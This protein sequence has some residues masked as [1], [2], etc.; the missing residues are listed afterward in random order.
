MRT[1]HTIFSIKKNNKKKKNTQKFT[2][3][4]LNLQLWDIVLV[5]QERVRSSGGKQAIGVRLYIF[6]SFQ[7]GKESGSN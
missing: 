5:N 7:L 2:L 1:Q 6:S 4:I 3:N